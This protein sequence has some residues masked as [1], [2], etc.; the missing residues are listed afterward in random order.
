[1]LLALVAV[2]PAASASAQV[3]EPNGVVV[4]G[5]SSD[6]N[7]TTLQAYFDTEGEAIDAV[8]Q[9]S[10]EPGTFSPLCDFDATL[11]LS[12]SNALAGIAWYNVPADPNVS[13]TTWYTIVPPGTPIGQVINASDIRSDPNYTG[14]FIGFALVRTRNEM[15]VDTEFIAY[16]SEFQR[17]VFCSGCTMPDYWKMALV[18]RSTLDA[19][20]YY[21]G[22]EDWDGANSTE[23]FGNDGDFND[24]VFRLHGISCAGGG[25][26][27]DTGKLGRCAAGLTQCQMVDGAPPE[28]TP[29]VTETDE[30]C[31][32]VDNDCDG[33]I[34]EGDLC[35]PEFVCVRGTCV[36]SCSTGE[37]QCPTGFACDRGYCK[38]PACVGIDCMAGQVCRNGVCVDSC[39][40][41]VCPAGQDC[42]DG[43]C[44]DAC[45]GVE[46]PNGTVC[47]RGV[48]VGAC[49]CTG[50]RDGKSCAADGRCVE[51]GCDLV[52]C[53]AGQACVGGQCVDACEGAVC[54]GGAACANGTCGEPMST[55]GAGGTD[56]GTGG[57]S[58]GGTAG[59][60]VVTGGTGNVTGT[61]GSSPGAG[62]TSSSGASGG[63]GGD[64]GSRIPSSD[65]GC[66]CRTPRPTP[67]GGEPVAWALAA[68]A[69]AFAWGRRKSRGPSADAAL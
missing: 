54:P 44:I 13:P 43:R 66:A 38:D 21:I 5:P 51:P 50:C 28:C 11:V 52:T 17:N 23:W 62:A 61:G 18:Y 3:V 37:F 30:T 55:A 36:Q 65:P 40:G 53:S 4:P 47:D 10:P 12:E 57:G 45:A 6:M 42:Q 9:A 64:V 16:H 7:E 56:S 35:Q 67:P 20:T 33:E 27:C 34:D 46:C 31:D 48:C 39:S 26:P 19:S 29:Q 69:G 1:M 8:A 25:M 49:S 68:L 15:G 2:L 63:T 58:D 22:F 59:V 14:G 41:I 32:D 60:V 24:K